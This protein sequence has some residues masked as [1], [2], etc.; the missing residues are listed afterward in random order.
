MKTLLDIPAEYVVLFLQGGA[1]IHPLCF[2]S[3]SSDIRF[4]IIHID[5]QLSEQYFLAFTISFSALY[6]AGLAR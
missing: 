1:K 4:S 3:E 6:W 2:D 5:L